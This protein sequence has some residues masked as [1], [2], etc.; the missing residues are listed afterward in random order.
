MLDLEILAGD[1]NKI[2]VRIVTPDVTRP[3]NP[4]RITIV[5]RILDKRRGSP[6][7]I[8]VVAKSDAGSAHADL[9]LT[10]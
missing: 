10:R 6:F 7:R 8:P 2:S 1:I 4:L 9:A 5:Q 3:V